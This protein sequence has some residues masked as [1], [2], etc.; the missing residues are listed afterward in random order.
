MLNYRKSRKCYQVL[1]TGMVQG[2]AKVVGFQN[3]KKLGNIT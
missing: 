3:H 2:F 1:M